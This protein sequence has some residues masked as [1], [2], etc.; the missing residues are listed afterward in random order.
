MYVEK[1]G[2]SIACVILYG[3][4]WVSCWLTSSKHLFS[5]INVRT[6]YISQSWWWCPLCRTIR[7]VRLYS[8]SSLKQQSV[9][10]RVAPLGHIILIPNYPIFSISPY[11]CTLIGEATNTNF[12]VFDLPYR[13]SYSRYT[14]L[15]ASILTITPPMR[16]SL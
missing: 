3:S 1:N 12:I 6:R 9:G 10:R 5:Y 2:N 4:T 8:A 14:A 15:E 13:D 16:F 7:L 11:C